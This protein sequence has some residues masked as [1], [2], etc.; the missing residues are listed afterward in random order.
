MLEGRVREYSSV[1]KTFILFT[2]PRSGA[3]LLVFHFVIS[4]VENSSTN[5]ILSLHLYLISYTIHTPE[6]F[7]VRKILIQSHHFMCVRVCVYN[8]HID[9]IFPETCLNEI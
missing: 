8:I 3:L 7:S 6:L 5:Q 2:L 9:S 4:T 1:Q